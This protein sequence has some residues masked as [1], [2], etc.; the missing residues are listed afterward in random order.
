MSVHHPEP[1]VLALVEELSEDPVISLERRDE[2][3]HALV[4]TVYSGCED[5]AIV[6]VKLIDAPPPPT[7]PSFGGSFEAR[8]FDAP[9]ELPERPWFVFERS[10]ST[11]QNIARLRC[12][13]RD[14][15]FHTGR[16]ES[17]PLCVDDVPDPV[18]M[19]PPRPSFDDMGR[20][21]R[22]D[23][24]P[25]PSRPPSGKSLP[26]P[27]SSQRAPASK[28]AP[29][30]APPRRRNA[31]PEPPPPAPAFSGE[32]P[33]ISSATP[34]QPPARQPPPSRPPASRPPPPRRN[35][36][37]PPP[38]ARRPATGPLPGPPPVPQATADAAPMSGGLPPPP[39]PPPPP[40]FGEEEA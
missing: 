33:V 22:V 34:S 26:L 4:L 3:T 15:I 35:S 17:P 7:A 31:P 29:H 8:A 2:P 20:T 32:P 40:P 25:P 11:E 12:A 37:V 13:V 38:P 18:E 39:P 21:Q 1:W 36:S 5:E 9:S 23:S 6:E 24:R 30:R 16:R 10:L 28:P 14:C 27:P 19:E